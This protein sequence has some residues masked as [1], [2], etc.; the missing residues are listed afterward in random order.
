MQ[1]IFI[2]K[3]FINF[4]LIKFPDMMSLGELQISFPLF[5]CSKNSPCDLIS[6]IFIS[7]KLMKMRILTI[8]IY[9]IS[10]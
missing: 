8:K 9:S 2:V 7:E 1:Y 4:S 5:S 10:S 3:I 6:T